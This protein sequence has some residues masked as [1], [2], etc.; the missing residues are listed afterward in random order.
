MP[1]KLLFLGGQNKITTTPLTNNNTLSIE[2]VIEAGVPSSNNDPIQ[3][4]CRK[5]DAYSILNR[6]TVRSRGDKGICFDGDRQGCFAKDLC[7]Q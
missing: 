7:S 2:A 5:I 1:I 4:T 6:L 3:N